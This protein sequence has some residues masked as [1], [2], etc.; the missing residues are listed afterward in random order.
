[1]AV[2]L[3]LH[4]VFVFGVDV[5]HIFAAYARLGIGETALQALQLLPVGL[6]AAGHAPPDGGLFGKVRAVRFLISRVLS[7]IL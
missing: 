1:M 7:S 6:D 3:F 5:P 4:G 2:L